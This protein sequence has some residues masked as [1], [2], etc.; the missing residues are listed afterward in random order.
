MSSYAGN[1]AQT[2]SVRFDEIKAEVVRVHVDGIG[3]TK[4]SLVMKNLASMFNVKH[5]QDLVVEAQEVR[6]KLKGK[7]CMILWRA[8]SAS[9]SQS[10][11]C[12]RVM[13]IVSQK[14]SQLT[15]YKSLVRF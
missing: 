6:S 10:R 7:F 5:F 3:R 9:Y 4:E 15:N 13:V 11:K 1:Q 12:P 8:R 2:A 14:I